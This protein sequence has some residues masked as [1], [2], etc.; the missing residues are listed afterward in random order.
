MKQKNIE[1]DFI[2]YIVLI[3]LFSA[4]FI[5]HS[6]TIE[7]YIGAIQTPNRDKEILD[8][9]SDLKSDMTKLK[10]NVES[11]VT[12]SLNQTRQV[13]CTTNYD[14]NKNNKS[15]RQ[16]MINNSCNKYAKEYKWSSSLLQTSS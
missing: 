2:M 3:L 1:L 6:S 7:T 9:I 16:K 12:N 13:F 15:K 11:D 10:K 5:I 4:I 8:K 14:D